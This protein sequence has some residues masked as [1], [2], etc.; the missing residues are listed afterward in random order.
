MWTFEQFILQNDDVYMSQ[1][2]FEKKI[3][4]PVLMNFEQNDFD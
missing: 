1:S 2:Q 3:M 4:N